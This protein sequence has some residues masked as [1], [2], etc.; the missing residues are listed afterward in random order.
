MEDNTQKETYNGTILIFFS[1]FHE[2][3]IKT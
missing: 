1:P 3:M 2:E